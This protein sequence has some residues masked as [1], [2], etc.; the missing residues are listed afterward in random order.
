VAEKINGES[1]L[2]Q[3][4]AATRALAAH[5]FADPGGVLRVER[6]EQVELIQLF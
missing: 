2:A 5:V 1:G 4:L 3:T 6:A